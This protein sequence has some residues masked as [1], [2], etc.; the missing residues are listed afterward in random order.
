MSND[1]WKM[2]LFPAKHSPFLPAKYS[3]PVWKVLH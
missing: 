2:I 1:E 3:H